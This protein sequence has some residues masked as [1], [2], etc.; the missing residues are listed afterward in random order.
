[1]THFSLLL[2]SVFVGCN[3]TRSLTGSSLRISHDLWLQFRIPMYHCPG[4]QLA[5]TQEASQTWGHD[6][7]RALFPKKKGA[8]SRNK[9]GTSL[10]IAKSWG[11]VPP[12][13]PP[14]V[15]TSMATGVQRDIL[16]TRIFS[17]PHAQ[18]MKQSQKVDSIFVQMASS[19]RLKLAWLMRPI[20]L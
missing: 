11:H 13:P 15:P 17:C 9:K 2:C 10:S 8:F 18:A 5:G 3:D 14:P 1:M 4:V 7:S 16:G 20:V 19:R 6:T 12:V